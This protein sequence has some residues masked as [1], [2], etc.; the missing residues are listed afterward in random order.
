[1]AISSTRGAVWRRLYWVVTR[2]AVCSVLYVECLDERSYPCATEGAPPNREVTNETNDYKQNHE[3][4]SMGFY[5]SRHC[6]P[7]C[8]GCPMKL[9][10]ITLKLNQAKK[11]YEQVTT[12]TYDPGNEKQALAYLK[13]YCYVLN[14]QGVYVKR[15]STRQGEYEFRAEQ[16]VA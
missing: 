4:L 15:V 1:M 2:H 9:L 13:R 11:V 16:K 8:M 10:L 3:I 12:T 6:K 5:L 14:D 7:N